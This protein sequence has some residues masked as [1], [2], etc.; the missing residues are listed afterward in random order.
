[1]LSAI[2]NGKGRRLPDGL[3]PGASLRMAFKRS[4][5]ILTATV[6]ER[7][8]YLD[9]H[10]LWQILEATF[11]PKVLPT[12]KLVALDDVEFWPTWGQAR[13][14]IGKA[15]EPDVVLRL[16]VGDPPV[17]VVLI[18]ECK[19]DGLQYPRQWAHEWI[20]CQ[21]QAQDDERADETY[22][23]ALGG[24]TRRTAAMVAEFTTVIGRDHAIEIKAAGAGWQ[25]LRDALENLSVE[26]AASR[27]VIKDVKAALDLHGFRSF[28][29]MG[30]LVQVSGSLGPVTQERS[31]LRFEEVA[32]PQLVEPRDGFSDFA[33]T[34]RDLRPIRYH[35]ALRWS[36]ENA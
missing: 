3:P 8:A 31:S 19:L 30:D 14:T 33:A 20:A 24:V 22:L 16:T 12:R 6:F 23:L 21:A 18:V 13:D 29:P 34:T 17:K 25:Q 4:E 35:D 2:L 28:R 32:E 7:L 9:G 1:M 11:R 26:S 5:D 27:R 10:T 15:V 36:D